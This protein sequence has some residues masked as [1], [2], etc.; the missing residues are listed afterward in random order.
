[1]KMDNILVQNKILPKFYEIFMIVNFS[2]LV[3]VIYKFTNIFIIYI[4][5]TNIAIYLLFNVIYHMISYQY[6]T[7]IVKK[8]HGYVSLYEQLMRS[9]YTFHIELRKTHVFLKGLSHNYNEVQNKRIY[10]L[11]LKYYL[12]FLSLTK[13]ISI[14]TRG[15]YSLERAYKKRFF[16]R[17]VKKNKK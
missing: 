6:M 17:I 9:I 1:M 15:L 11:N 14:R 13:L 7:G 8:I 5:M 3:S 16:K 10:K 12:Y 4:I 2:I